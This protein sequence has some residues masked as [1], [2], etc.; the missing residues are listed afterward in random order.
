MLLSPEEETH[1]SESERV[2]VKVGDKHRWGTSTASKARLREPEEGGASEGASTFSVP[3]RSLH[4]GESP[5]HWRLGD[6]RQ[7]GRPPPGLPAPC[8]SAGRETC[9]LPGSQLPPR[10]D[11]RRGKLVQ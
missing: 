1:V 4:P 5:A 2:V 9:I 6:L 7:Q 10:R 11:S 3:H 8:C